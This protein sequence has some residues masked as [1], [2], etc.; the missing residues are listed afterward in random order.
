M[1]RA[2]GDSDISVLGYA[3][4]SDGVNIDERLSD[5]IYIPTKPFEFTPSGQALANVPLSSGAYVSGGG[6]NGGC[7][8]PRITKVGNRYYMTYVAYNGQT[9]PRVAITSIKVEDFHNK[10]WNWSEPVLISK[11]DVVDKNACLFPEKINGKYVIFHRIFPN[12]LIDYLDSLDFD[13]KTFL[14]GEYAIK[15]RATSWDSRKVGAGCPPIKTP[16]GWLMIYHAVGEHDPSRYKMGAMLLDLKDPT[17]VLF[18]S[19]TPILQPEVHYENE[20]YKYGVAY[21]CGAVAF[22]NELFVYYGGADMV[23][24]VAKANLETFLTHLMDT[25]SAEMTQVYNFEQKI[26]A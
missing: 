1:Y 17:K 11:P 22:N 6:G 8:D 18:R 15:P 26:I 13:G 12:I 2:I 24:C 7:E 14:K 16:Y 20:G 23:V 3:S 9:A 19:D 25:G 10:K 4:S 21:P 5:P